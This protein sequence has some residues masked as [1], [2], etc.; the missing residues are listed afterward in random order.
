MV[1]VDA[2]GWK[3]ITMPLWGPKRR[4]NVLIGGGGMQRVDS[5]SWKE[6]KTKKE[7]LLSNRPKVILYV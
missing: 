1:E 7:V 4:D 6:Q 5:F 3:A 2:L